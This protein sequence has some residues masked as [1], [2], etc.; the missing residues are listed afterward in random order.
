MRKVYTLVGLVGLLAFA[1][2][3]QADSLGRP[4]TD[5]PESEYLSLDTLKAKLT[6]VGYQI[7][8]GEIRQACGE[9]Y[10]VD[11]AG[12][13]AELFLDPTSGEVVAGDGAA[14][15]GKS[16]DGDEKSRSAL[17]SGGDDLSLSAMLGGD[18][19][20]REGGKEDEQD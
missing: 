11:K 14:N 13:R 5:K 1:G 2:A 6:E 9:F 7:R 4:C 8:S 16:S 15:L 3:A 18:D 12:K 19:E 20:Q 10:V 17:S